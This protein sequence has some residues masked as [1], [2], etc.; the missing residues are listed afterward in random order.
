MKQKLINALDNYSQLDNYLQQMDIKSIL[1]VCGASF[2]QLDISKY[3]EGLEKRLGIKMIKFERFQPNPLYESVVAGVKLFQA[4]NCE[5]IIAVGGGSAIDVAKCI[6]LYS[7]MNP[8]ENYLKQ[9]IVPNTISLIAV[10][11]TAGSGSEATKYVVIYY[12]GKK[13]S[14]MHESC[15]PDVVLHDSHALKTLPVY[16]KKAAMLD[17]LCHSIEAY[18]SVNSTDQSK[19][20]SKK[21]I[22]MILPNIDGYLS[23]DAEASASML[24]AAYF[25]GKAINI[26]QTTAGHAMCYRLTSLYGISHGHAA[27]M[28]LRKL[29]P[30]MTMN[31]SKCIDPRGENYLRK[32]FKE[33]SI[34]LECEN[35]LLAA[36]K[37]NCMFNNLELE[38]PQAKEEDY[39]ILKNSVNPERLKNNPIYMNPNDIDKLYH[40]ILKR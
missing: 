1:L 12:K 7:N 22:K 6:K 8:V 26:T 3:F 10:P 36:E 33:I 13:R 21:A 23:N 34:L 20:Y 18:W 38:V 24:T 27:S 25:A 2:Q 28:C 5:G 37:F 4:N 40:E 32:I 19:E 29:W 31:T 15:I 11:T 30:W 35:E 9:S 14:I 16:Q 17:A 39:E